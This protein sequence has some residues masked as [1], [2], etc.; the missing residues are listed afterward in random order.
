[1]LA[2]KQVDN[3]KLTKEGAYMRAIILTMVIFGIFLSQRWEFGIYIS[4]AGFTLWIINH[5]FP[6][7]TESSKLKKAVKTFCSDLGGTIAIRQ[8]TLR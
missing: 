4:L 6:F 7:G 3:G 8:I 2:I 1:M 5:F